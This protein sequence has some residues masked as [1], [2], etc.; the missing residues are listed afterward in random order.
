[1]LIRPFEIW[2]LEK[3][4]KLIKETSEEFNRSDFTP[5]NENEFLDF[6]DF[7]KNKDNLIKFFEE[8]DVF[9]ATNQKNEIIWVLRVKENRIKSFFV[10][11]KYHRKG[12][13]T[14]LFNYYLKTLKNWEYKIITVLSSS[15]AVKFYES[16]WFRVNWE[17]II[18][19]DKVRVIPM[20]KCLI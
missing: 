2:D 10:E 12:V 9:V 6:F 8:S 13:A 7:Q 4:A 19:E 1:M 16:L 15:Y 14:S 20:K 5:W 18:R 11:K 17:D 3:C